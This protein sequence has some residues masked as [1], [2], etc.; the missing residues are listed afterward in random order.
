M[1]REE[2]LKMLSDIA[3]TRT[4]QDLILEKLDE[5]EKM[6]KE[7]RLTRKGH[8]VASWGE[9]VKEMEDANLEESE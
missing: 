5:L 4:N 9:E 1:T 7:L 2:Q 6:T 3:N 8:E